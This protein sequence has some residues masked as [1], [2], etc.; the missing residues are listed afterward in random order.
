MSQ[1]KQALQII[2]VLPAA[3]QATRIAPLP[4]SK[5][6]YPIGSRL[7]V[8]GREQ[9]PKVACHYLLE[10]MRLADITKAYIIIRE[11]KWDIPAY[12]RDG[13]LLGMH[14]G[15]F[16]VGPTSGPPYTLDE[17]Y[18]FVRDSVI[19]FGFPDIVFEGD[20]AFRQLLS[21]QALSD[22]D[23]VLG[24]FPADRPEKMD[25][26]ELGK[27]GRVTDLVIQPHQTRL[28]YSWDVAVWTPRF[29]EF[30]HSYLAAQK[31]V[32]P[33]HAELSVGHVIQAAIRDGLRVEG[34][35]VSDEPYLDIGTPEG[36]TK[37]IKRY[38][39]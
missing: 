6:L 3:G 4:C 7:I 32:A 22:A 33:S 34:V 16:I 15:Y 5:E 12:L 10:K 27:N 24:L 21:Q 9:R 39:N 14:L 26:V 31:T 1:D 2:G 25:V 18:P 35:P 37:A 23:I 36:L 11:G 28:Q 38:A 17:A 13:A 29:T 19:A 8:D 20:N 30:L